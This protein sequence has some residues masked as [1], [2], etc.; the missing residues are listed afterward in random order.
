ML[1]ASSTFLAL[2]KGTSSTFLRSN[3]LENVI[4]ISSLLEN[5]MPM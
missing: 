1:K 3:F 4:A 5:G 2:I